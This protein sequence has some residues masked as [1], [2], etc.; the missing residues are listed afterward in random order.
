MSISSMKEGL[1]KISSRAMELKKGKI[2]HLKANTV[3][4]RELM[5]PSNGKNKNKIKMDS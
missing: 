4:G 3:R 5:A 2:I 1:S